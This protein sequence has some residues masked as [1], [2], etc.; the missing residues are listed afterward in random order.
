[1]GP[2]EQIDNAEEEVACQCEVHV[3]LCCPWKALSQPLW[4][5]VPGW[6][7]KL[8]SRGDGTSQAAL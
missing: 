1:M 7:L 3:R 8:L 5:K 6:T 4:V 2:G